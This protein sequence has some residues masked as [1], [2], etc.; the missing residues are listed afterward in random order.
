M[1]QS[2]A[3][4]LVHLIFST[5]NRVPLIRSELR[6]GL[7]RY[8]C[9]V[10]RDLECPALVMNSVSDHVHVLFNLHRTRSLSDV[11]MEIKRAS[12]VWIREQTRHEGGIWQAGF[13]AFSVSQSAVDAVTEYIKQ[14][15]AHH[16]KRSFQEE[17]R[18]ILIRHEVVFDERYLWD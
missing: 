16:R 13:G 11:A 6:E 18:E 2:L 4:N 17:F 1:S 5:K 12:S 10:L 9:A 3:R 15:E 14:Q 7:H 8:T